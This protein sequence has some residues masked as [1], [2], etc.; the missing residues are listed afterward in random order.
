[1]TPVLNEYRKCYAEILY[2]WGEAEKAVEVLKFVQEPK[3]RHIGLG[4]KTK[5]K[6]T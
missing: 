4:K 3:A 1:L 2:R 6:K 5:K